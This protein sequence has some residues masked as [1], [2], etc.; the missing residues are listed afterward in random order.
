MAPR[1]GHSWLRLSTCPAASLLLLGLVRVY[2]SCQLLRASVE[3]LRPSR[4]RQRAPLLPLFCGYRPYRHSVLSG[5]EA[6]LWAFTNC[7]SASG[8]WQG[9]MGHP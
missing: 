2:S 9:S 1:E 5:R 4:P 6:R 8:L 3:C 7:H